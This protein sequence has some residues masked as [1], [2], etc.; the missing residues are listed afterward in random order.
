LGALEST[1]S[2]GRIAFENMK[3]LVRI[4]HEK[5]V[6]LTVGSHGPWVPFAPKG[7][8]YQYEMELMVDSGMD[9]LSVIAAGTSENARF[10]KIFDRLGSLETGKLADLVLVKGDPLKDIRAMYNIEAV[11]LNGI[12]LD[13]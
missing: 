11:M 9:P 13:K 7:W 2:I 1:D 4:C 5:G 10:L 12:W 8:S 6:K 3:T